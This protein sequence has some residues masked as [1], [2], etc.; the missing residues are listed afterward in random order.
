MVNARATSDLQHDLRDE[1]ERLGFATVGFAPA[2]GHALSGER[3]EQWLGEGWHGSM[4]WMEARARER[5]RHSG[6]A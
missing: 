2:E 4:E 3:L 5:R 6:G 1:A